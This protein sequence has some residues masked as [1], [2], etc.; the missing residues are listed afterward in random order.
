MKKQKTSVSE[1]VAEAF[2]LPKESMGVV[3][4]VNIIGREEVSVE[5]Y[6]GILEYT[7]NIVRL[8]TDKFIIKIVGADLEIGIIAEEYISIKGLISGVEYNGYSKTD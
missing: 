8:N 1:K 4:H 5:G 6:R 3:S 2:G 7:E